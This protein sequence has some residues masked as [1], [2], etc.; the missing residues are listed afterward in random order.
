MANESTTKVKVDLSDLKKEFR[1]AQ[2]HIQ[3]VNSEFKEATAGMGKW[4]NNADGVSAKLKQLNGVLQ[5]ENTKLKSLESQYALVAK[6]QGENSKG[7]QELMIK[8]NKQK[9]AIKETESSIAYYNDKLKE[10]EA[11]SKQTASAS[12]KL[13]ETISKQESDLNSLK[14]EYANL[15]LEQGKTSQE[16]QELSRKIEELSSDLK[17]NKSALNDAESAADQFDKSLDDVEDSAK[18]ASDGFTVMKGALADLIADGIKSAAGALKDFIVE[19][20]SAYKKFQAQTGASTKEMEKFSDQMDE[21]YESGIGESLGDIGDKMAYVKQVTGEVDPSK[22]KELTE[23]AIT[24][25]D[26]F[27][28]DFNETIRGVSNLMTHFGIDSEEAFDLFAKG[29]QEGLDYTGELGDNIAEYGG[30]FEQAGY[31]AEEYF[32]LL[33]NGSKNGAYNLDKVNDSINEVKNRLGDG[34]IEKNIDMFSDG[35]KSAFKAWKDG[36]GTMKDVIDS[37]VDDIND[38]ENEQEALNMAATAFGTM[39]EDANLKVV[40]SLKSTGDSFTNVK[41][42]ME[43]VKKVRYDDVG[44]QFKELGRTLMNELVKPLAEKALPQF[45]KLSE[46]AIDNMDKII[47]VAKTLGVV[48]MGMFVTNKIAGFVTSLKTLIPAFALT[49]TATDAQTASTLAL[50]TAWLASPITWLIA[51][52]AALVAAYVAYNKKVEE[53]IEKEYGLTEAQE[54]SIEASK[55]LKKSYDEMNQSRNESMQNINAEYGYIDELKNEYNGLIDSNGKV[56]EGY[57][58]R[59]NFIINQLSQAL[60][61]EKEKILENVDAN[62]QLG[63]S[64]DQIIEKK[65]AEAA[66]SANEAAYTE[67]IQ[68][69]SE[70]L[71]TYQDALTTLDEAESKY[72]ETKDKAANIMENYQQMLISAPQSAD[73]YLM[74]NKKILTANDEAKKS[75]EKAKKGVE[76]AESAYVGY[77]TTIQNYEGLSSA[78]ISGDTTKI[79]DALQNM[80]NNFITAENGTKDSLTRQVD[81]LTKQYED[82][83]TAIENGTP[84]VTQAQVDAAKEMV[85]KA[86]AELDKLPPEAGETA[87]TAGVNFAL[88]LSSTMDQNK[89]TAETISMGVNLALATADTEKTGK[90]QGTNY[91]TGVDSTKKDNESTAK[92]VSSAVNKALGTADTKTT[93]ANQGG[94]FNAGLDGTKGAASKVGA[95]V[96]GAAK[97]GLGSQNA[98]D[99]GS[100]LVGTF[101]KGV[102]A[103]NTQSPAMKK[104]Q[105]AKKGVGS[106]S[107]ND[108][109]NNFTAGFVNG[110]SFGAAANTLWTSA[111]NLGKKALKSLKE[112]IKEGSP[113]KETAVSGKWFVLGFANEI[114]DMTKVAAKQ[115]R[116]M[117]KATVEALTD[118]L[119]TEVS[120]P[121]IGGLQTSMTAA[122]QAVQ[123]PRQANGTNT[124]VTNKYNFYQTNNSPKALSRLE[125]YRQ[126]KNQLNFAKGV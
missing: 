42:K 78:I 30:N 27:G 119:N 106:V 61:I 79:N 68:K 123:H 118:E 1:D 40:K 22:I 59:A 64:I 85:D 105:E 57:E 36:K 21:I 28:S 52:T 91:K 41:G 74:A 3:L 72:N 70:A 16:A 120:M 90:D 53:S 66:L 20:D 100:A 89:A 12:D 7:A 54:K 113:S 84:G 86:T 39:G 35:T 93:G 83:K 45:E 11:E 110:M 122:R 77:N 48:L 26:T 88:G 24:L 8:I 107:A 126:T 115:A 92:G 80:Q 75:Y 112:S 103:V 4:S 32:Q 25:E 82:M 67:A 5:D 29:S 6:E 98:N 49:K 10:M 14:S 23:N 31:S 111:W 46:V 33:A 50:N 69:R 121:V 62:G 73:G 17:Q 97:G 34:T 37:I 19:S 124:Q 56:K 18:D 58:D 55:N 13:R 108:T 94:S 9:A 109:G 95:V 81:N 60:G 38:C 102:G 15:V 114:A 117:G 76:D 63:D 44:T 71:S 51:G 96:S 87:S 99:K 125:I 101:N 65:K 47:P 2:R 43:E 104:A 116:T